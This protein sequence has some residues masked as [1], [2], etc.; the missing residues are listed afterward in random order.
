[1]YKAKHN[2]LEIKEWE[3]CMKKEHSKKK[4]VQK[5]YREALSALNRKVKNHDYINEKYQGPAHDS[6]N[7][8]L[9]IGSFE[10]KVPLICHNFRD[11]DSHLRLPSEIYL[12]FRIMSKP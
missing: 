5:R 1:M 12:G 2:L 9:Q 7:K 4:E 8:K 10:T 11:Y 6:C 3:S